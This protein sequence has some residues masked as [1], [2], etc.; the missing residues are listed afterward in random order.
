LSWWFTLPSV[1]STDRPYVLS[2]F[3]CVRRVGGELVVESPLSTVRIHLHDA[4]VAGVIA[5]LATPARGEE[6]SDRLPGLSPRVVTS[7]FALLCGT[8]ML[9]CVG[10]EDR[11]ASL[12]SWEFHDLLFHTRS[13]EGRHDA[14]VGTTYHLALELPPPPAVKP[15]V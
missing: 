15:A 10:E 5:A 11:N 14:P 1:V 12:R 2:R 13:R 6:L 3:A 4:W 9:S 7:L 8:G